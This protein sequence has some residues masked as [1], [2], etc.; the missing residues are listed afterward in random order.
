LDND[1]KDNLAA[2][3]KQMVYEPEEIIFDVGEPGAAAFVIKSGAV[4]LK[5]SGSN[6]QTVSKGDKF[7]DV[8]LFYNTMRLCQAKAKERTVCLVIGREH[9]ATL[10]NIDP[11]KHFI[12][13]YA[14][15]H[16]ETVQ[17]IKSL[18]KTD[19]DYIM[20]AGTLHFYQSGQVMIEENAP[21][22]HLYIIIE[23]GL[24]GVD[25]NN[26]VLDR[27]GVWGDFRIGEDINDK[28]GA[29]ETVIY[30]TDSVVMKLPIRI[31]NERIG[32]MS[33][34]LRDSSIQQLNDGGE[35][36]RFDTLKFVDFTKY[37]TLS[38]NKVYRYE[39]G[40][41]RGQPNPCMVKIFSKKQLEERKLHKYSQPERSLLQI[42]MSQHIAQLIH[43]MTEEDK[44]IFVIKYIDG[45][46]LYEVIRT[47]GLLG[48]SDCQFYTASILIILELLREYKYVH[49]DIKPENFIVDPD[50][51]LHLF[52]CSIVKSLDSSEKTATIIGT[53]HYMAPEIILKHEYGFEVDIWSTGICLYEFICG[54]V[55]FG[56]DTEDPFYIFEEILGGD[57]AF[58]K[59]INDSKLINLTR[60]MLDM[61]QRNREKMT[62]QW[63]LC[64][65][66]RLTQLTLVSTRST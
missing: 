24:K 65:R 61:N 37:Y 1:Q 14:R 43:V 35:E 64:R 5:G 32:L 29:D 39:I 19:V 49:R 55:P 2:T 53:P 33:K 18:K 48:S 21:V 47:M 40:Y 50:G 34:K 15:S 9:L 42:A 58:P 10:K 56:D 23:G 28:R 38:E 7:G 8:S 62:P 13:A 26:I 46:T 45:T 57:L 41:F 20:A 4:E 30:S 12:T 11:Q 3:V 17:L 16:L 60:L 44:Q 6:Q 36:V 59:T 63:L 25:T 66:L 27:P 52:D 54:K 31:I 51:Y 22:D